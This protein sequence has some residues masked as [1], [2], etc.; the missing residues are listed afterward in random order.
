PL[1]PPLDSAQVTVTASP[2]PGGYPLSLHDALPISGQVKTHIYADGP[3]S[4]TITVD[5]TDEDGTFLAAGSKGVTVD[6]VAPTIALGGSDHTNEG[7][8]YMMSLAA[9]TDPGQDTVTAYT[10]HWRESLK[11]PL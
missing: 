1:G 9:I 5:L 2:T 8:T 6:N 11:P 7:A 3:N 10:I 4:Y